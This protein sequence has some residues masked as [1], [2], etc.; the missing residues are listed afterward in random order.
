MND[1]AWS[2]LH[3]W[4]GVFTVTFLFCLI[5]GAPNFSLLA[6]RLAG[7]PDLYTAAQWLNLGFA[8]STGLVLALIWIWLRRNAWSFKDFGLGQ[9]TTRLAL[10]LGILFSLAWVALS[11]MGLKHRAPEVALFQITFPRIVA[12]LLGVFVAFGEEVAMRGLVMRELS[13]IK[14]ATYA[15]IVVSGFCHG[16]YH[17]LPLMMVSWRLGLGALI[18]GIVLGCGLAALYVLGKRSLTPPLMCHGLINFLGE[19]Y[20]LVY[21]LMAIREGGS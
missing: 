14:V 12:A 4:K 3:G 18:G 13:Q 2:K 15:Q 20:L 8:V 19:P 10:G 1:Q 6:P 5:W 9:P 16:A 7:R 21:L 11:F 17:G